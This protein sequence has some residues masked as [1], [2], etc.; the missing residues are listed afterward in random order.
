MNML[1]QEHHDYHQEARCDILV[2]S[3]FI[4]GAETWTARAS[5]RT[6]TEAIEVMKYVECP[7]ETIL[8]F[9]KSCTSLNTFRLIS[10]K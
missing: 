7:M 9:W 2:F 10:P 6:P 8:P 5:D 4:Y 3:T 1:R